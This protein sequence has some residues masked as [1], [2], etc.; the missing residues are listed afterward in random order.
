M[1]ASQTPPGDASQLPSA[2]APTPALGSDCG[3]LCHGPPR[4]LPHTQGAL[5]VSPSWGNFAFSIGNLEGNLGLPW[6]N[7]P[8]LGGETEAGGSAPSWA[9]PP[10]SGPHPLHVRF[11][12]DIPFAFFPPHLDF[13]PCFF[14]FFSSF[15]CLS[16]YEY[17][18][19]LLV[20]WSRLLPGGMSQLG[21]PDL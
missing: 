8:F 11:P 17:M 16:L 13:L 7:L 3:V 5:L 20:Q 2:C 6:L 10:C 12:L 1:S 21:H 19:H 18:T 14:S 15:W 9:S 4:F